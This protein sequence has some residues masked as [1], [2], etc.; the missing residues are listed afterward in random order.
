MRGRR[1]G[2]RRR[3]KK[4]TDTLEKRGNFEASLHPVEPIFRGYGGVALLGKTGDDRHLFLQ[5]IRVNVQQTVQ[6]KPINTVVAQG[7]RQPI[8]S[9][10][11]RRAFRSSAWFCISTRMLSADVMQPLWKRQ[12]KDEGSRAA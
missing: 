7:E 8:T 10:F 9:D 1:R 4:L 5:E 11:S 2:R 6:Q 3:G 12:G